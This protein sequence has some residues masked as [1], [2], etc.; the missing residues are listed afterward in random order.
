MKNGI[1]S[2]QGLKIGQVFNIGGVNY[3]ATSFPTRSSVVGKIQTPQSGEANNVKVS[4]R[5]TPTMFWKHCRSG[6][7]ISSMEL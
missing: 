3:I 1:N 2:V 6:L 5:R 4:I 7:L